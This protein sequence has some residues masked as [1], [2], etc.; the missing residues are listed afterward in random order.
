HGVTSGSHTKLVPATRFLAF[1]SSP[2]HDSCMSR[3]CH[4]DVSHQARRTPFHLPVAA[5]TIMFMLELVRNS[6]SEDSSLIFRHRVADSTNSSSCCDHIRIVLSVCRPIAAAHFLG[7]PFSAGI[8]LTKLVLSICPRFAVHAHSVFND[9]RD[10]V[11]RLLAWSLL[12]ERYAWQPPVSLTAGF[13]AFDVTLTFWLCPFE[14][15]LPTVFLSV[16]RSR[17]PA[18]GTHARTTGC[19]SRCYYFPRSYD[20]P[21][22]R[23]AVAAATCISCLRCSSSDIRLPVLDYAY[24]FN[25]GSLLTVEPPEYLCQ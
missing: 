3:C 11:Y 8:T 9:S 24:D 7:F 4:F 13:V 21:S 2:C 6:V 20:Q 16:A 5:R 15:H 10:V 19:P 12:A 18:I 14:P 22:R 1:P 23:G 25:R 17:N